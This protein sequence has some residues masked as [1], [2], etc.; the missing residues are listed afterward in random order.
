MGAGV[1]NRKPCDAWPS[2]NHDNRDPD[3]TVIMLP[4][5]P[6]RLHKSNR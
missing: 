5:G 4:R 1:A 2:G 6:V 3:E